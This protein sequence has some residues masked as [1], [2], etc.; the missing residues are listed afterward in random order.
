MRKV[1]AHAIKAVIDCIGENQTPAIVIQF[2]CED[3]KT[4]RKT[5]WITD[6][7]VEYTMNDLRTC[8]FAGN[9]PFVLD[10]G[11]CLELLPNTVMLVVEPNEKNEKYEDVKFINAIGA[12]LA[13]KNA[14]TGKA[15]DDIRKLFKAAA[16][17]NAAPSKPELDPRDY[18]DEEEFDDDDFDTD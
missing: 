4:L 13:V 12:G 18:N 11:D 5:C 9:D 17:K 1:R 16:L 14:P 10:G 8:G 6:A 7:S 3:N 15:K 2:E